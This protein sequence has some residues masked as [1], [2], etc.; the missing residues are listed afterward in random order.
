MLTTQALSS[1]AVGLGR[2][3]FL[4]AGTAGALAGLAPRL[5]ADAG[6]EFQPRRV[7]VIGVGWF[8]KFD[9]FRLMQVAPV[10]V[11]AICDVDAQM[12]SEA[13]EL[14]AARQNGKTPRT[15][16]DHQ[17]LLKEKDLDIVIVGTPDHWH[18]LP[19]IDAVRAGAHV[20]VEKPTSVD[21]MESKAMLEAA[22]KY[23][24]VVQVGT[25]RRSTPHL[26]EAKK[27]V[28]D[29]GLLGKIGHVEVCC[30]YHMRANRNPPPN[31]PPAHLDYETW[32]GPAPMRPY[33]DLTHPRSWRAFTEYG[34]GIVGDMCV[35]MLDM[36]R[37]ML[38][39]GAVDRVSSEGG[40]LIQKESL[41]NIADSQTA[42]YTFGELPVVWTH[43]SWGNPPDPDYPWAAFI[44]GEK[45]TLK[46]SVHQYDFIPRGKR[47]ATL[48]GD[49]LREPE[50]YPEEKNEE[51]IERHVVSASR[52]HMRDFLRAIEADGEQA[53]RPVADIEQGVTSTVACLLAN[54]SRDLGRTLNWD[55]ENWRV[56]DDPEAT[57][58]LLRPYRQPWTHP[59]A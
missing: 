43:R 27:T 34:N 16:A 19:M 32:T 12:L 33:T 59:A 10:E 25:Q 39:L 18:A 51:R 3:G 38:D 58:R 49:A 15:Y 31:S 13:A 46:A 37:W 14:I 11:V 47:Q 56:T 20:Y 35:H 57:A 21:V 17:D 36:V 2:R 4:G 8:G 30:Y 6:G 26:M 54:L 5:Y 40:I 50:K 44:Y 22:R 9:A 29:A 1:P 42:T 23:N 48:H 45:G 24:R 7:G 28:V 55:Q 52:E 41:A 53:A